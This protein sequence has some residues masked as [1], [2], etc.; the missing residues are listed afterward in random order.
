[1]S[2]GWLLWVMFL[3][4]FNLGIMLFLFLWG[5]CVK[6][7]V[8]LDGI[9]GYVW[10]YGVLCEGVCKLLMWWLLFFGVMF[11][12]GFVYLVLYLGFGNY[13]GILGWIV[14]GELVCDVVVNDV[15]F[16]ELLVCFC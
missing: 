6:I 7:L 14:Y 12:V 9:S 15:K 4:V 10:V 8:L 5:L 16:D 3:I 1:M 11:V 13:K 2:M